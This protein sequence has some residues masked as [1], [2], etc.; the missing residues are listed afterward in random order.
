MEL[1]I[2][3]KLKNYFNQVRNPY[4]FKCHNVKVNVLYNENGNIL[5]NLL[6]TYFINVK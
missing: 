1:S 2:E 6:K 3:R 5:Y 4:H